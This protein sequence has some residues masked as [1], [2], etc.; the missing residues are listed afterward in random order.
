MQLQ[1]LSSKPQLQIVQFECIMDQIQ[2]SSSEAMNSSAGKDS[3]Y[4]PLSGGSSRVAV[5]LKFCFHS[6][7]NI[8]AVAKCSS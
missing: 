7:S 4:P 8:D 3:P 1:S 5:E 6:I 2:T